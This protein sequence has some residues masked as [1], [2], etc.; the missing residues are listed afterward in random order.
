[1]KLGI[2]ALPLECAFRKVLFLFCNS[3]FPPTLQGTELSFRTR[4]Y[5]QHHHSNLLSQQDSISVYLP[6]AI[7]P[8]NRS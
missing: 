4:F 7:P 5:S 6:R 2:K 1:M 3:L 8:K